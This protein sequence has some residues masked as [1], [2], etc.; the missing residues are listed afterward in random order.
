MFPSRD[1]DL[2]H[3][4][5]NWYFLCTEI[6]IKYNFGLIDGHSVYLLKRMYHVNLVRAEFIQSSLTVMC[7]EN[8][9]GTGACSS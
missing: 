7:G 4:L 8:T 3:L 5:F 2:I 6:K 1:S 9:S